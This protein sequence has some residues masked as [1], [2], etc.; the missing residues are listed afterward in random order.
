MGIAHGADH[1]GHEDHH[2]DTHTS[3][4]LCNVFGKPLLE[5]RSVETPR[6][7][8]QNKVIKKSPKL[9]FYETFAAATFYSRRG[10]PQKS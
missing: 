5:E 2:S 9:F 1:E 10:P 4:E 7:H 6:V 8:R 3:C